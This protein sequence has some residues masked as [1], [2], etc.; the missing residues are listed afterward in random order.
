VDSGIIYFF[1]IYKEEIPMSQSISFLKLR[2]QFDPILD[3]NVYEE[4]G[5]KFFE[6]D[7]KSHIENT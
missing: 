1:P 4:E 3:F 5:Q 2:T 7:F 6:D